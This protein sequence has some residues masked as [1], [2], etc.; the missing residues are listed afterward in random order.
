MAFIQ[1]D[2]S[3]K[4]QRVASLVKRYVTYLFDATLYFHTAMSNS[5]AEPWFIPYLIEIGETWGDKL[6]SVPLYTKARKIRLTNV[7]VAPRAL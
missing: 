2:Y 7:S 6:S 4:Y 5:I 3:Y 1:S